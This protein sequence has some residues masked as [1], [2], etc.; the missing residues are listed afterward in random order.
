[1]FRIYDGRKHF[2]QW[3]ID[4]KLLIKD[5]S[6]TQVHF[7]NRTYTNAL[8]CEVVEGLVNVPNILL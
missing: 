1:M 3:D 5:T 6:I 7:S 8:V 2:Y 4:R